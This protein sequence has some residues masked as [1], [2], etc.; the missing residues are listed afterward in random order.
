[1]AEDILKKYSLGEMG[2]NS[3][4]A[5]MGWYHKWQQQTKKDPAWAEYWKGYFGKATGLNPDDIGLKTPEEALR[6]HMK[7]I[8]DS[9]VSPP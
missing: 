4:Y 5:A 7:S 6:W 1:M 2:S 8:D 9:L 3:P